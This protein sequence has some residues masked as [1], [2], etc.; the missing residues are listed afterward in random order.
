M[1]TKRRKSL[2]ITQIIKFATAIIVTKRYSHVNSNISHSR[3]LTSENDLQ[4]LLF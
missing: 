3:S 2:S 4:N 1:L